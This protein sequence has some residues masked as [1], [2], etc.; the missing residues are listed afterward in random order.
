MNDK[1]TNPLPW[2]QHGELLI[3]PEAIDAAI[4]FDGSGNLTRDGAAMTIGLAL[5]NFI[6]SYGECAYFRDYSRHSFPAL[7]KSEG[8]QMDYGSMLHLHA[9]RNPGG[10]SVGLPWQLPLPD[11]YEQRRAIEEARLISARADEQ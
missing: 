7:S 9:S 5:H 11:H 4:A 8:A 1:P 10:W 6:E 2:M 3:T